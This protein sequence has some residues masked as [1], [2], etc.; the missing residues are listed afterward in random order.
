MLV[1]A[2]SWGMLVG[3]KVLPFD[4]YDGKK[5]TAGKTLKELNRMLQQEHK[6]IEGRIDQRVLKPAPPFNIIRD[7]FCWPP[8]RLSS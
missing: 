4:P 8:L 3:A 2:A 5:I 7:Y 1:N 6:K